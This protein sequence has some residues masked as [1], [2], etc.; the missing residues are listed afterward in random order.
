MRHPCPC[1]RAGVA[2][3][4]CGCWVKLSGAHRISRSAPNYLDA[5][6]FHQAL[7]F[8]N[9]D[10]LVWGGDWPHPR[11]NGEMPDGGHL[12]DSFQEWTPDAGVRH[13]ILVTNPARLYGF[14]D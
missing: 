7:V 11:M 5:P 6:P 3:S 9:P 14:A 1:V 2:F 8:E 10:R 12:L 13:R 4:Q